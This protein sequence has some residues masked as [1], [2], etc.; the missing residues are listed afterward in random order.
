MSTFLQQSFLSYTAF[1]AFLPS[2]PFYTDFLYLILNIHTIVHH[3]I[4]PQT[5]T[6]T[7]YKWVPNV[8]QMTAD[9]GT[10]NELGVESH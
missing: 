7:S 6:K 9:P 5:A 8:Y 4:A 1:I 3:K 10:D 2:P